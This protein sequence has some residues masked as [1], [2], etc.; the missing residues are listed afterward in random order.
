MCFPAG[1]LVRT[2]IQI[3]TATDRRHRYHHRLRHRVSFRS[4]TMDVCPPPPSL[5]AIP[6]TMTELRSEFK[7]YFFA[8]P[9]TTKK[10]LSNNGEG[11]YQNC[12]AV[13]PSISRVIYAFGEI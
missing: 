10:H 3:V 6:L 8:P 7:Q 1:D 5:T 11:V 13:L 4:F 2:S 12:I 9:G